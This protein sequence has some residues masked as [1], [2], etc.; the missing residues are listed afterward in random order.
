[1]NIL[2]VH[3]ITLACPISCRKCRQPCSFLILH[4]YFV[5]WSTLITAEVSKIHRMMIEYM[6]VSLKLNFCSGALC[7]DL[8]TFFPMDYTP[9][10]DCCSAF[11]SYP[12]TYLTHL[13]RIEFPTIMSWASLF[14]ILGLLGCIFHF[15]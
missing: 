10:P 2:R 6:D 8:T 11:A 12:R 13:C 4:A 3:H 9:T 7:L 14:P 1:M 15:Y 5:F